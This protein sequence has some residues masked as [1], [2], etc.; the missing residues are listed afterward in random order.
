MLTEIHTER[1]KYLARK[2]RSGE[3]TECAG[4]LRIDDGF[5]AAGVAC[6]ILVNE[7]DEGL[8]WSHNGGLRV[9]DSH[10]RVGDWCTRLSRYFGMTDSQ[11]LSLVDANDADSSA[12][13]RHETAAR[14]IDAMVSD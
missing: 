4:G 11:A 13:M 5:C 1:L 2:L 6:D 3:Y 8:S 12:G 10:E 7:S 14:C 9:T